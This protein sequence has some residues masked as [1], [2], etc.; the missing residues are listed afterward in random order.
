MLEL[1]TTLLVLTAALAYVNVRWIKLPPAIGLLATALVSALLLKVA[2]LFGLVDL[3]PV[4]RAI[5]EIDFR[6]TLLDVMLAPL[7]FAAALHVDW[8][9]LR[10]QAVPVLTLASVGLVLAAGMLTAALMGVGA[11]LGFEVPFL[12]ALA[13]GAL[14]A[15]TDPIAVG[16]LLKKAGVPKELQMAI[17]GESLFNDGFGVVLFLGVSAAILKGAPPSLGEVGHLLVFE[18]AGGLLLGF[19]LGALAVAAL[20]HVDNYQVEILFTLALVFGGYL[21]A[22]MLHVSG[23]L[24]MVIAGLMLGQQGRSL[25]LSERTQRRLDEFWEL[26]DEFLNA[27]LFVLIGVEVLV[28]DMDPRALM[29]GAALIPIG[30][31]ARFA[32]V[33]LPL[34]PLQSRLGW[35]VGGFRLL[36]WAGVRGGISIALALA[37]PAG[38]IRSTLLTVAYVI[39]CFSVL[40]QGLTMERVAQSLIGPEGLKAP[41]AS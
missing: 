33:A 24:G 36:T 30:L 2:A 32:A 40:V 3:A 25:A 10:S 8:N 38:P 41:P 31:L 35:P 14:I 23:V 27:A 20:R 22:R 16:A 28:L 17:T 34:I 21:L 5:E 7:L 13:F 4:V 1:I 39:V 19:A 37:L 18:V 11:L 6:D 9:A 12:W 26:V 15:P 29:L